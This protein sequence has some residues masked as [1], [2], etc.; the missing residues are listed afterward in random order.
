MTSSLDFPVKHS[1][2]YFSLSRASPFLP[3]SL[4]YSLSVTEALSRK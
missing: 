2:A 4:I 3:E 1:E